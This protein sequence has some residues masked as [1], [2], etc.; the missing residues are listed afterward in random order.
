MCC[1]LAVIYRTYVIRQTV[2]R[3]L[4]LMFATLAWSQT[5]AMSCGE[6]SAEKNFERA[7]FVFLAWV[8]SVDRPGQSHPMQVKRTYFSLDEYMI[9]R[10][11]VVEN[12]KGS[13]SELQ[14]IYSSEQSVPLE[15]GTEYIFFAEEDGF[16]HLC[17]GTAR[18]GPLGLSEAR[19]RDYVQEIRAFKLRDA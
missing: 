11:E 7:A 15:A 1:Y 19:F 2:K 18:K 8:V 5:M 9:A 10:F 14:F 4:Y 17:Y 3:F 12:I 16:V 13:P 6:S